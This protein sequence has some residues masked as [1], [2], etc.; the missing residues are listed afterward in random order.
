MLQLGVSDIDSNFPLDAFRQIIVDI[1]AQGVIQIE[2]TQRTKSGEIIPAEMTIYYHPGNAS[3]SPRLI[4]FMTDIT[5][6]K[7]TERI[8]QEAKKRAEAATHAKSVFLANMSHEIR[9]PLNAITGMAYLIRRD[10]LT[11][12]QSDK[13]DKLEAASLHL[14]NILNDILDLSKI[15][16]N[17]LTPEQAPL[18]VESVV[19]NVVSM[20][21]ERAA[22]KHLKMINE[23]RP[24]PNNLEGDVTRLQQALLNYVTNAVKFTDAGSITLHAQLVEED[25]DSALLHFEV[26]DTGIGIE[27]AVLERLF[28][29]FEQADNSTTRKYGGTGL[30]LAITRKLARLMGG[31]AGARSTPGTGSSFWFTAR[32]KKGEPQP[33]QTPEVLTGNA[34]A[35]LKAFHAGER[36][37]VAED[38]P[39]NAEIACILLEDAGFQVDVA[40]DGLKA[41]EMAS[42]NIYSAILMDMQMPRMDGLDATRKIRKMPGYADTPILAMTANAY[43]DDKAHCQDAGMNGFVSKPV[44]SEELYKTLLNFLTSTKK[45]QVD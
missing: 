18:R 7:E 27:P 37:L 33:L 25:E 32:L 5:R 12:M 2:T 40:E 15:D 34:M 24:L 29:M 22:G 11:T 30:G 31:E 42:Q 44:P 1:R 14:L 35:M 45:K 21:A 38:E 43:A 6:R 17:K 41:V 16:A 3:D 10:H 28:S 13:L 20:V 36:L 26:T 9:T 8:L 4:A 23:V 39:L 19:S